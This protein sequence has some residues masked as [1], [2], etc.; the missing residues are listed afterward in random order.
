MKIGIKIYIVIV[1]LLILLHVIV[2]T[3]YGINY[4][5]Y[6]L[7]I[8]TCSLLDILYLKNINKKNKE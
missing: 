4:I 6:M 1:I 2:K 7:G 5:S 8:C 3:I